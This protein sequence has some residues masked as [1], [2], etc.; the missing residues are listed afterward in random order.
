MRPLRPARARER[1]RTTACSAI[2]DVAGASTE[3]AVADQERRRGR[4]QRPD[5]RLGLDHLAEVDRARL[6]D[7]LP[8]RRF[9]QAPASPPESSSRIHPQELD[10]ARQPIVQ[11]RPPLLDPQ[12]DVEIVK[13]DEQRPDD[14]LVHQ[15]ER[16]ARNA[17]PGAPPGSRSRGETASRPRPARITS[18]TTRA[19]HPRKPVQG[20]QPP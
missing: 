15:P 5:H 4:R 8:D 17:Q 13:P 1:E 18:G 20:Q 9:P 12:R 3:Q 16:P 10:R 14:P 11:A 6:L 19:D 7:G 2:R